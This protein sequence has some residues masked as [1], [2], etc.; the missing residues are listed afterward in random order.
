[1]GECWGAGMPYDPWGNM[2][3]RAVVVSVPWLQEGPNRWIGMFKRVAEAIHLMK[4][5]HA[6]ITSVDRD[7]LQD[8]GSII[9]YHKGCR[10]GPG[11]DTRNPDT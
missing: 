6:V 1:M 11:Y 3:T 2:C 5:K 8:S 9:W 10:P 7:E 4:V